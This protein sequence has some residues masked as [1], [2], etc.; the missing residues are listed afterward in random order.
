[1]PPVQ[2]IMTGVSAGA[3]TSGS[4]TAASSS[5]TGVSL[6]TSSAGRSAPLRVKMEICEFVHHNQASRGNWE[7][8][9]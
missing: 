1:M 2:Y 3:P 5:P 4:G 6:K 7:E 9:S 8:L